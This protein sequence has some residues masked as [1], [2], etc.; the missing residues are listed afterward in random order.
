MKK[1]II[2]LLALAPVAFAMGVFCII[3]LQMILLGMLLCLIIAPILF[4]YG[5]E[6]DKKHEQKR[7]KRLYKSLKNRSYENK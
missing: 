1:L 7:T 5:C 4:T 6:L 2:V 3:Q